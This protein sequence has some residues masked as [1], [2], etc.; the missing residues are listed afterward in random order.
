MSGVPVTAKS[1]YYDDVRFTDAIINDHYNILSHKEEEEQK[2]FSYLMAFDIYVWLLIFLSIICLGVT[3]YLLSTVDER[4]KKYIRTG[5]VSVVASS[6][7]LAERNE[8]RP[9]R[10]SILCPPP[11]RQPLRMPPVLLGVINNIGT[12]Q[13]VS[14]N[15][16]VPDPPANLI[17]RSLFIVWWFISISIIGCFAGNLL[18]NLVKDTPIKESLDKLEDVYD[19]DSITLLAVR[20]TVIDDDE[21]ANEEIEFVTSEDITSKKSVDK[22]IAGTHAMVINKLST[23]Y[24]ISQRGSCHFHVGSYIYTP[25]SF[26]MVMSRKVSLD[27][28]RQINQ[29]IKLLVGTGVLSRWLELSPPNEQECIEKAIARK[30]RPLIWEDFEG[31]LLILLVGVALSIIAILVEVFM[32]KNPELYIKPVVRKIKRRR[33][34][35]WNMIRDALRLVGIEIASSWRTKRNELRVRALSKANIGVDLIINPGYQVTSPFNRDRRMTIS[36]ARDLDKFRER[37][38]TP[39]ARTSPTLKVIPSCNVSIRSDS[40]DSVSD[41]SFDETIPRSA[42]FRQNSSEIKRARSQSLAVYF[43]NNVTI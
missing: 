11:L 40:I 33:K 37:L 8:R 31:I 29:R 15:Q 6:F 30:E 2:F 12:F 3:N 21:Y 32:Q 34:M 20:G 17:P 13:R 39:Q 43:Q 35:L 4:R 9:K 14:L 27:F 24:I 28:H 16:S 23:E 41:D 1:E 18:Q 26:G 7:E 36:D 42:K 19:D 10:V 38:N 5:R 22:V 25:S